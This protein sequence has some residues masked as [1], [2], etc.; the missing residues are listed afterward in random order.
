[1]ILN[2]PE[3]GLKSGDPTPQRTIECPSCKSPFEFNTNRL[4]WD[5]DGNFEFCNVICGCG[6]EFE[7]CVSSLTNEYDFFTA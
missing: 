2:N 7:I 6:K 1:M 4:V 5:Y 3:T